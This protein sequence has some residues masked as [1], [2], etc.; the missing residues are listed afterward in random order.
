MGYFMNLFF[1]IVVICGI[2]YCI[3]KELSDLYFKLKIRLKIN[4]TIISVVTMEIIDKVF[5]SGKKEL[6]GGNRIPSKYPDSYILE[7]KYKGNYYKVNDYELF[8]RFKIG[9][10]VELNLI[11]N[12][13][14]NGKKLSYK[15]EKIKNNL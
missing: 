13:D 11:E 15:L 10:T 6:I 8:E 4:Q 14:K 5:I 1:C 12:L 2:F 9:D 7:L 3:I